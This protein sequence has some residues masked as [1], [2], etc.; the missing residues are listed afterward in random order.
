MLPR[1]AYKKH[2]VLIV[3]LVQELVYLFRARKAGLVQDIEHL[4]SVV[5]P[6]LAM[7]MPLQRA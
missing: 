1:I 4:L 5:G 7:E 3:Q 2:S 6:A